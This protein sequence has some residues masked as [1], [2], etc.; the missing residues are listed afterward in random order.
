MQVFSRTTEYA[1]QAVCVLAEWAPS[2]VTTEEIARETDVPASYLP[3]VLQSLRRAGIVRSWRGIR[4]GVALAREPTAISVLDVMD[5]VDPIE[6]LKRC[7]PGCI[8]HGVGL[9]PMHS[10]V[11]SI[12]AMCEDV[13]RPLS[14]A[15]V[16]ADQTRKRPSRTI[17]PSK[18]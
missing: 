5:A 1:L 13:F 4:G 7:P 17:R 3:K 14:L 12:L 9:C 15:D 6:R 11:D 8:A 10:R 16:L 2:T 18:R